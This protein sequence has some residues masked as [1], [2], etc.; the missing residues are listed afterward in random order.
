MARLKSLLL[1]STLVAQAPLALAAVT[2]QVGGCLPKLTSFTTIT[3]ALQASPSATLIKV[4]PGTYNEQV[5]ITNPVTLEGVN[6]GNSSEVV[7]Q[8]PT[9]GLTT[10]TD[11]LEDTL[12]PQ[13]WVESSGEVNLNN[14]IV[15]GGNNITSPYVNLVG[16]LYKNTSGKVN[17]LLLANQNTALTS[18]GNHGTGIWLVGGSAN[19]SVVI[20]DNFIQGS[21]YAGIM[22]ESDSST[23]TLTATISGNS[24]DGTYANNSGGVNNG[25]YGI[26]FGFGTSAS[27]SENF[28]TGSSTGIYIYP[29]A[30]GAVSKN[31]IQSNGYTTYGIDIEGDDASVT[32]NTIREAI[33]GI[34]ADSAI[35]PVT[36]NMI[37]GGVYGVDFNCIAGDNV[38]SNTILN[39]GAAL[40]MVPTAAVSTN[41]YH[42]LEEIR[43]GGC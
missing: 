38:H 2:Y 20:E 41:T 15:V 25:L 23:P 32:S 36:G 7:I 19:P 24:I 21:D 6:V 11:G 27:V 35:T 33:Y 39:A 14:L 5:I 37:I 22:M 4:C 43:I 9:A 29:A 26:I 28:A 34:L 18:G 12:A 30:K 40:Y 31:T 16:V 10:T 13:V 42:N 8:I 17:D 3:Q 1:M